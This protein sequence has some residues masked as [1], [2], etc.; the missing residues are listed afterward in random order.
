M[1]GINGGI[2]LMDSEESVEIIHEK[3]MISINI[4][5]EVIIR[6]GFRDSLGAMLRDLLIC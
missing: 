3:M 6:V 1:A 5:P 2:E 4:A